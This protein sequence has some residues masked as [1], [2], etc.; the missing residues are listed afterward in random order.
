LLHY[1]GTSKFG[2]KEKGYSRSLFPFL[3]CSKN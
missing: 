3:L 1:Y 2:D